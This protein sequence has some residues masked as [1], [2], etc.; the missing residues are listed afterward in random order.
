M[1]MNGINIGFGRTRTSLSLEKSQK[2]PRRSLTSSGRES[3]SQGLNE[4]DK[5]FTHEL[6]YREIYHMF[7][8]KIDYYVKVYCP[9]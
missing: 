1:S 8:E 4:T 3:R 5:V 9:T 2:V 6:A 7:H